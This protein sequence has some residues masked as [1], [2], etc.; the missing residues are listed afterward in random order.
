MAAYVIKIMVSEVR[1]LWLTHPFTSTSS[2]AIFS[3]WYS[4]LSPPA[5]TAPSHTCTFH[6]L[7]DQTLTLKCYYM[8]WC[9]TGLK[10]NSNFIRCGPCFPSLL[11]GLF[12]MA[13]DVVS[14]LR[15]RPLIT[16]WSS[17]WSL[18]PVFMWVTGKKK[19]PIWLTTGEQSSHSTNFSSYLLDVCHWLIRARWSIELIHWGGSNAGNTHTKVLKRCGWMAKVQQWE[20]FTLIIIMIKYC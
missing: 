17:L 5:G 7:A 6:I 2:L 14:K 18:W 12:F 13:F 16:R 20:W 9:E 3:L 15:P 8:H 11:D 1:V 19:G 4:L 10:W